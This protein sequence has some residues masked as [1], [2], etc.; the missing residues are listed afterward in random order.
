VQG[1]LLPHGTR[2]EN[3]DAPDIL[4]N[5]SVRCFLSSA[6]FRLVA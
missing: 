4:C 5:H 3:K 1:N 2:P 6:A